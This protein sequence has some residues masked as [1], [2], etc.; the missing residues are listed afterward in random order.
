MSSDDTANKIKD[1]GNKLKNAK[2]IDEDIII[3]NQENSYLEGLMEK[4]KDRVTKL[5]FYMII[6]DNDNL[7][8]SLILSGTINKEILKLKKRLVRIEK[9]VKWSSE[10]K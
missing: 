6:R 8:R 5:V 7:K 3:L 4:E 9:E 1:Y 10:N 2:S